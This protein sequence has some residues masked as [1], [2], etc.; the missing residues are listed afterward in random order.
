MTRFR[1]GVGLLLSMKVM[2]VEQTDPGIGHEIRQAVQFQGGYILWAIRLRGGVPSKRIRC[3]ILRLKED[4]MKIKNYPLLLV[5]ILCVLLAGPP[6]QCAKR[7]RFH[8]WVGS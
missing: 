3:T 5:S 7:E 2:A 6:S 8:Q 4:K 1:G